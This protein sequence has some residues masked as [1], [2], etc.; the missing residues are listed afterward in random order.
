MYINP[1]EDGT[2]TPPS[3]DMSLLNAIHQASPEDIDSYCRNVYD[4]E[5]GFNAATPYNEN[6][7]CGKWQDEYTALHQRRLEQLELIR[8]G[9]A[10]E[11]EETPLFIS[12][13]CKEVPV[14]GNRGC[15]GTADRMS[16]K[17]N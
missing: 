2:Y 5:H 8:N 10:D 3:P 15:G 13:L 14:N 4:R 16:G 9:K 11:L 7:K 6:G 1:T 17:K 12:Y